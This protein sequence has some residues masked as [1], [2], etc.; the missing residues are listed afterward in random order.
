ML[1]IN[2]KRSYGPSLGVGKAERGGAVSALLAPWVL[3]H[4]GYLHYGRHTR[5]LSVMRR[6]VH[7]SSSAW[8]EVDS[9]WMIVPY[10]D[11]RTFF[12]VT[13]GCDLRR[14]EYHSRCTVLAF[15]AAA[16]VAVNDHVAG[17]ITKPN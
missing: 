13:S 11:A 1:S 16:F 9:F 17:K 10:V 2:L 5:D 3:P 4:D 6:R 8:I 12:S 7:A 15:F 14:D